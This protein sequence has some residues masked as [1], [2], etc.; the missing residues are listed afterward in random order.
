MFLFCFVFVFSF[1]NHWAIVY[2]LSHLF[3]LLSFSLSWQHISF[4]YVIRPPQE[5]SIY[6]SP[7]LM[8]FIHWLYHVYIITSEKSVMKILRLLSFKFK[9]LFI[10]S[11]NV[12]NTTQWRACK[13][14][15]TTGLCVIQHFLHSDCIHGH[16][17]EEVRPC[18]Y[19]CVFMG[20]KS[21]RT[22]TYGDLL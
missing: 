14:V 10:L 15:M 16:L 9:S 21:G 17:D 22:S 1:L 19:I 11:S 2:L 18:V 4:L 20:S 5:P 12:V 13:V 7:H 8:V 3:Y 6:L